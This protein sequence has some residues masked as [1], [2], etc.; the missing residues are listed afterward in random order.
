MV[1]PAGPR[2]FPGSFGRRRS[3]DRPGPLRDRLVGYQRD[4][5][6]ALAT[7]ASIT[8][9]EGHFRADVD[10]QQF[11]YDLYAVILAFHHFSR[12]LREPDA[13]A[14]A[15]RSFESLLAACRA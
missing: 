1:L 6:Q 5:L 14:R 3:D 7:A 10:P 8:V 2:R 9:E 12:L 15:R 4:W 13:E 11:A